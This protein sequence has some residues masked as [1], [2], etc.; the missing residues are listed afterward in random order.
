M[1]FGFIPTEG[2][3]FFQAALDEA[4]TGEAL[5]FDSVWLE[6]HHGIRDHYWP[7]PLMA[8]AGIATRTSRIL[9]GTDIAVL[10]F[11]HPVRVAEDVA[12]LDVMS[13]GRAIFGA[14]IG[15]RAPEFA[16]YGV[17]LEGRG[18]RF[19]EML[20]IMR[21][22]WTQDRVEFSGKH[23]Q[24]DGAIEPR[25]ARPVPIWLGGWGELSL[26][27][28]AQLADAWVPGPTAQLDKLLAAQQQYWAELRALN[29]DPAQAPAPLT[30]EVIIADTRAQAWELAERFLMVNY[31]DE[32]GGGWQHP[33]IGAQDHTPVDQLEALSRD[34]FIVGAP[35]DCITAIR[36]FQTTFG[37]DHLICRL[38]FPGM[39]HD[40]IR[41]ELQLLSAEVMPAFR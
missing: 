21:A 16:L 13:G 20:Q 10:P 17:P 7:S 33:L 39:P 6:E 5:G 27:R 19:V 9:L 11:Y 37:V 30:R 2:G 31:R 40:H 24:L 23:Y 38:Y 34:R 15:Y 35:E 3:H 25:P 14:A 22:L 8:L 32:Y 1:K 26:K 12:L 4:V 41:H 29:H 28:A 36:R 18:G